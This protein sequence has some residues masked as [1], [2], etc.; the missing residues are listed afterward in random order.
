[1]YGQGGLE[2]SLDRRWGRPANRRWWPRA[3]PARGCSRATT[4]AGRATSSPPSI[5]RCRP[6]RPPLW[7]DGYGGIAILDA[8]TGASV[9]RPVSP[10]T[11]A[12]ARVDVQDRS[13]P[14]AALTAG[15]VDLDS[16]YTPASYATSAGSS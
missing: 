10:W 16:Y 6:T 8:R 14:S 9:R 3:R 11:T 4:A 1:M 5:R 12:A 7:R 13:R 15:V 2:Q